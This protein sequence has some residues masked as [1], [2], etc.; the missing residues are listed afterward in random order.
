MGREDGVPAL[1]DHEAW[2]SNPR[3][4]RHVNRLLASSDPAQVFRRYET[5]VEQRFA[6]HVS[7]W[8]ALLPKESDLLSPAVEVLRKLIK[9]HRGK[10]QP[11]LQG[12]LQ[13]VAH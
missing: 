1:N 2:A 6:V 4:Q 13:L 8:V 5:S 10:L 12:S 9:A 3:L 11:W 7:A